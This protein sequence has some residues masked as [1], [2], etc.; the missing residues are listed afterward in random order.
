VGTKVWLTRMRPGLS[1]LQMPSLIRP[2]L[3]AA[4]LVAQA[5]VQPW[6]SA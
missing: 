5:P 3:S 1:W 2:E 4:Q 6:V